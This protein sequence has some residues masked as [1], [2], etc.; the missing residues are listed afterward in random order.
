MTLTLGANAVGSFTLVATNSSGSSTS[1]P[2]VN[3][4]LT[5]V[6]SDPNAD[7][8]GD[9][10]TNLYESAIGSNP[11]NPSTTND[12]IP[13]GWAVFYGLSPLNAAA[14]SQSA[15][16]GLSY[17]QAFQRGL[18]PLVPNLVPPSVANVFPPNGATNYPTNGVIVVRFT[19][20]LLAGVDLPTAQKAINAALPSQSN[21]SSANAVAAAQVLQAYLQRTCCGTTAVPGAVQI[22]QN[23]RSLAG[24]TTLSNDRLS[25]TFATIQ[26]LSASTTYTISVQGVR[27][28]AG[29][30]MTQPFQSS[31]R[32][33]LAANKTTPGAVFTNPPNGATGV[34]I[35]TPIQLQFSAPVNPSTLTS[36]IFQVVDGTTNSALSGTLQTDPYGFT[37]SFVPA[38]PYGVGRL[39]LVTVSGVKD[40]ANNSFPLT[41]FSFTTGFNADNQGFHLVGTSPSN[42]LTAVPL[43]ALV[44]LEFDEPVDGISALIGLEVQLAGVP[45][46]GAIAL[47]DGNKRI[48]FTP[49]APLTA[50]ST[51]LVVTTTRLTDF[52]GNQLLNPDSSI[53]TTGNAVDTVAPQVVSLSAPNGSS[54]I[55]TNAKIQAQF[56]KQIDP[57]TNRSP[58]KESWQ[59]APFYVRRNGGWHRLSARCRRNPIAETACGYVLIPASQPC[60]SALLETQIDGF[61]RWN[62]DELRLVKRAENNRKPK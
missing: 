3:N 54:G 23:G 51:Y 26:P 2:S 41:S 46:P 7:S 21:F 37:A 19:E 18:N 53:F 47:S 44:V 33:G 13:D 25:L 58:G 27:D 35:N 31:F 55:P 36:Q 48:T 8:D 5:I 45:I 1:T 28:A 49:A 24:S 62:L 22:L 29:N 34:E 59:S 32:T 9:G 10:L 6:S 43:N 11:T 39:I 38:Q 15:P 60:A 56:S 4:T 16:D 57:L 40:V 30:V 17:L 61:R 52:S 50:N 20:P 12:G 42:G 14:A